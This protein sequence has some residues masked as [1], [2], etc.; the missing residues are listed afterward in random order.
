MEHSV[1]RHLVPWRKL[2][3][4][5]R[6]AQ[7][8]FIPSDAI[9]AVQKV[10]AQAYS[11]VIEVYAYAS[12]LLVIINLPRLGFSIGICSLFTNQLVIASS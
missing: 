10:G 7:S 1:V 3:Q 4:K 5:I 6:G 9:T 12:L 8:L 2:E 11:G